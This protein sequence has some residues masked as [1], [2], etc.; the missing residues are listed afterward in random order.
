[1]PLRKK[2][3][4]SSVRLKPKLTGLPFQK[5]IPNLLTLTALCAGLTS[6]RFALESRW[7]IAVILIFVSIVLDGMDGR[8]AR[9]LGSTSKFGAELDSFADFCN[10]GIVPGLVI[11]LYALKDLGRFGWSFVL[12]YTLCMV[13]RLARFNTLLDSPVK[14]SFFTGVSAP[15]GAL[16]ALLPM[17]IQFQ[18]ED[19]YHVPPISYG[20]WLGVVSCLLISRIPTFALKNG[21]VPKV[22]ILPIFI[23]VGLG[24]ASVIAFPWATL[25]LG[26]LFYLLSIPFSIRSERQERNRV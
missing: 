17:M 15:F 14:S 22:W 23:G 7:E 12:F 10:F 21:R 5:F 16:L 9:L 20:V 6:V 2:K 19:T 1:M 11:Y 25:T 18:L 13:L 8:I 3:R 4:L 24:T 26:G